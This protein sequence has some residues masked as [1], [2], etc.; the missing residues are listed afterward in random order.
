MKKYGKIIEY[1][2]ETG[3]IK[4]IDGEDYVLLAQNTI[5][6]N[7]KTSDNVEFEPELY[8]TVELKMN[9][10]RFDKTLKKIHN[11]VENKNIIIKKEVNNIF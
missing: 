7:L 2:G 4:G 11:N 5:D 6:K 9:I 3:N 1:D 8:E 10:A